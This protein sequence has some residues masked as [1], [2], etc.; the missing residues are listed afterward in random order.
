MVILKTY[1][2][3]TIIE[4]IVASL[5]IIVVFTTSVYFISDLLTSKEREVKVNWV[6]IYPEIS[7]CKDSSTIPEVSN[8][9][10]FK[11]N[12][13]G[14]SKEKGTTNFAIYSPSGTYYTVTTRFVK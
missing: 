4:T 8:I 2:A 1:K 13:H 12:M 9:L 5:I 14:N 3:S 7:Q 10:N 6:G 11:L